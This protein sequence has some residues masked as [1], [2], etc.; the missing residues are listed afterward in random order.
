MDASPSASYLSNAGRSSIVPRM[1]SIRFEVEYV[2]RARVSV[3]MARQIDPGG[4][5]I[6][7][8]SSLHGCSVLGMQMPRALDAHGQQRF[9]LFVF[10][11]EPDSVSRFH[12]GETVVLDA[13]APRSTNTEQ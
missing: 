12:V 1:M 10:N 11:V 9:D 5:E 6:D 8:N 7:E 4:F 3:V 2:S 13:T